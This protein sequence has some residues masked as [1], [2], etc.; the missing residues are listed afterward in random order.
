MLR[1]TDAASTQPAKQPWLQ[2]AHGINLMLQQLEQ[3]Q[4][5][6]GELSKKQSNRA[7]ATI[8]NTQKDGL[9]DAAA[10]D[11]E[12]DVNPVVGTLPSPGCI[13]GGLFGPST[14]RVSP[15]GPQS[16]SFWTQLYPLQHHRSHRR[17]GYVRVCFDSAGVPRGANPSGLALLQGLRGATAV[18]CTRTAAQAVQTVHVR[19]TYL[20]AACLHPATT[21]WSPQDHSLLGEHTKGNR[22]Y[23]A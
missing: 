5:G 8:F 21:L 12:D 7:V 23:I 16:L 13:G 18:T 3:A 9:L 17:D 19:A 15:P 6:P 4:R 1:P 11:V 10:P 2:P 20:P 22:L 14:S